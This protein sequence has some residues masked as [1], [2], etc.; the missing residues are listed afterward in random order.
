LAGSTKSKLKKRSLQKWFE[1]LAERYRQ[2]FPKECLHLLKVLKESGA[3]TDKNIELIRAANRGM[4]R[5]YTMSDKNH[6]IA[7]HESLKSPLTLTT[8]KFILYF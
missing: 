1:L 3:L 8:Y 4:E 2:I 6:L 5:K 7:V